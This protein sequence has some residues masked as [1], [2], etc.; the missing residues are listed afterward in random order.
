MI[1]LEA[2]WLDTEGIGT[3]L[4]KSAKEVRERIVV[5]PDFPTPVRFSDKLR[6]HPRWNAAEVQEWVL[7]QRERVSPAGGRPRTSRARSTSTAAP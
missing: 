1:P 4:S 7:A 3:M 6:S 5:L 2:L